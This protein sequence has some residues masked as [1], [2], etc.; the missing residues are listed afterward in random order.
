MDVKISRVKGK[1]ILP[2]IH[3][4][5]NL[6]ISILKDYPYLY[7][8]DLEYERNYLSTYTN[9]AEC[10]MIIAKDGDKIIGA[11]TAIPLEFE[12]QEFRQPFIDANMNIKD[13]FYFGESVLDKRYRGKGI[14][15]HF[16]KDREA[17]AREY[18]SHISAFC[19]VERPLDD[20][21][22]PQDY[23]PL[24]PI[25]TR[26]GYTKHPELATT[27]DWLEVGETQQSTNPMTFWL[28]NL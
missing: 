6:R 9:S 10:V 1:G 2:Y 25:W 15:H 7:Q 19:A 26:Y 5:A 18:G 12:V 22:R 8:G 13:I 23:R 14:Y 27:F 24:D 20:P 16:F 11:S 3:D 21:R 17:A 28:K 4:L